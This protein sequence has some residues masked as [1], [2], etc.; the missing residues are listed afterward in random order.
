MSI[1][2][3]PLIDRAKRTVAHKQTKVVRF[4]RNPNRR[5]SI[6]AQIREDD[7]AE[8]ISRATR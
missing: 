4:P 1:I 6:L 3:M 8:E 7:A 5:A 2:P